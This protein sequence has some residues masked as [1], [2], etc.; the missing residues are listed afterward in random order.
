[1]TSN[2]LPEDYR[3]AVEV[4]AA[5]ERGFPFS[6]GRGRRALEEDEGGGMNNTLIAKMS[7]T[8]KNEGA[9]YVGS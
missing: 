3:L 7:R 6:A 2:R 9:Q 8:K 4:S 5:R 1:M